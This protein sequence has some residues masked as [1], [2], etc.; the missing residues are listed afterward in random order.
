[1]GQNQERPIPG[2]R[3]LLGLPEVLTWVYAG[4]RSSAMPRHDGVLL[5][6]SRPSIH[7]GFDGGPGNALVAY[8]PSAPRIS[9]I[10]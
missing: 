4:G 5:G 10:S 3:R 1:M 8:Y 6:R 7:W 2:L 9:S